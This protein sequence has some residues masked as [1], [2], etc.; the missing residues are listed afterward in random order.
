MGDHKAWLLQACLLPNLN[1]I[2]N[3]CIRENSLQ[4]NGYGIGFWCKRSL[5]RIL[6]EPHI[7]AMHLFIGFFVTDFVPKMGACQGLAKEPLIPFN[8]QKWTLCIIQLSVINK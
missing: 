7:S 1:A 4:L 3:N 6:P 2:P 5:I 8:V